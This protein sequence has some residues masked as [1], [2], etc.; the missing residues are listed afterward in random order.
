M[1][2]IVPSLIRVTEPALGP[3][4]ISHHLLGADMGRGAVK[5]FVLIAV[6]LFSIASQAQD[7]QHD[8][9]WHVGG[10]VN[11]TLRTVQGAAIPNARIELLETA[12]GQLKDSTYTNPSGSFT[13]MRIPDGSYEIVATSGLS[14]VRERIQS[15][16]DLS[17]INLVLRGG[18]VAASRAGNRATVSVAQMQVPEKARKLLEKAQ[19]CLDKRKL[20]EAD[21]YVSQ[22]LEVYP[23]FAEA[24][25]MRGLMLLDGQRLDDAAASLEKSTRAD[26]SYAMGYIVLGAVYNMQSKFDDAIRVLDR[27]LTLMP[28]SWQGTFELGKAEL[29]KGHYE[30]A[31]RKLNK[32]SDLATQPYAPLHLAKA[33]ALLG[34]K[35]FSEATSELEAYLE[36]DPKSPNA[37]A[38]RESLDQVRAFVASSK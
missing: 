12:T 27:G 24:L 6:F 26:R 37:P 19:S 4:V 10:S 23:D 35:N 11:G 20:Q 31:I 18:E 14:E 33:H 8:A 38:V 32:A 17:L 28:Q 7:S 30:A 34:M 16:G 36:Q 22:A 21:T 9:F 1:L 25:T 5:F 29:G 13:L 2:N 3:I 15:R